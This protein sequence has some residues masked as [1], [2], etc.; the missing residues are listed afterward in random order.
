MKNSIA[1]LLFLFSNVVLADQNL[2]EGGLYRLQVVTNFYLSKDDAVKGVNAIKVGHFSRFKLLGSDDDYH[3]VTLFN[4][5]EWGVYDSSDEKVDWKNSEVVKGRLYYVRK[6]DILNSVVISYGGPSSG[7]LLVPFKYRIGSDNSISGEAMVGYYAGW[8]F[9]KKC[10]GYVCNITPLIAGGLSQINKS[11]IVNGSIREDNDLSIS[12]AT[13]L[14]I[15]NWADTNIGFIVGVDYT[16]D[17]Q[18]KH[19]GNAWVSFSVG[20]KLKN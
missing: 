12:I 4:I 14:L 1:I 11:E 7:P 19:E 3:K 17:D 6:D 18:W 5:F 9:E 2:E 13:G 16:G 10:L 8:D 20:W 15:K